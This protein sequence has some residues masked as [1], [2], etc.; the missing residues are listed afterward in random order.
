MEDN[1]GVESVETIN[2]EEET[3]H[4]ED[5]ARGVALE[6]HMSA[7]EPTATKSVTPSTSST[8]TSTASA[9]SKIK[10]NI[11]LQDTTQ[12]CLFYEYFALYELLAPYLQT[13]GFS[14]ICKSW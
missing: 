5:I 3:D 2:V 9:S 1:A 13:T 8:S 7:K 10:L 11:H 14:I 6:E 12:I 4:D